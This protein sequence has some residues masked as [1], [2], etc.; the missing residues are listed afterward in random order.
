MIVLIISINNAQSVGYGQMWLTQVIHLAIA[1]LL[2]T[3]LA[4]QTD[5]RLHSKC[6]LEN[7]DHYHLQ[8]AIFLEAFNPSHNL[9]ESE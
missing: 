8:T 4:G 5:S 1:Y 9:F 3:L 7:C 6:V 2:A